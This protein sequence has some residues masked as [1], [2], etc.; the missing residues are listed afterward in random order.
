MINDMRNSHTGEITV[1]NHKS[2][3]KR[4]RQTIARTERNKAHLSTVRTAVKAMRSFITSGDK[5]SALTALPKLQG[6][7]D[8]L[9]K[10]GA[11]NVKTAARRN[12]RLAA[13]VQKL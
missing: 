1:A 9:S 13:Q 5:S 7:F 4:N 12:S 3:K 6:L 11:M 8:R 2:A 10:S